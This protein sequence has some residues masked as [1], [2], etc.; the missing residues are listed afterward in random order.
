MPTTPFGRW[1]STAR[2]STG[3]TPDV[4]DVAQQRGAPPGV[5]PRDDGA[6]ADLLERVPA[7]LARL[8]LDEVEQ[9]GLPVEHEVVHPQEHRG[10]LR[11]GCRRP[12]ALGDPGGVDGDPHVAGARHREHGERR[13]GHRAAGHDVGVVARG[14][15][16]GDERS[17]ACRVHGVRGGGIGLGVGDDF[18]HYRRVTTGSDQRGRS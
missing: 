1:C 11:H 14:H 8:E 15:D 2:D 12:V 16:P 7:G 9:L 3:N 5:V 18:G 10:T 17:D 4:L 6:V 13:P